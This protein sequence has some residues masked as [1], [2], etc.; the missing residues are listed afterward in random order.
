[1]GHKAKGP[2]HQSISEGSL[3]ANNQGIVPIL[4]NVCGIGVFF[5]NN[6]DNTPKEFK[7]DIEM[8]GTCPIVGQDVKTT[9]NKDKT[10]AQYKTRIK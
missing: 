9:L 4:R 7:T 1:M 5:G 6:H 8:R 3:A 2:E 10:D